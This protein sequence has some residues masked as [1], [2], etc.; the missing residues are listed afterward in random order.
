MTN[1]L[2]ANVFWMFIGNGLYAFMQWIQLSIIAKLCSPI[3][4]GSYTLAL[5]ITAPIFLLLS[6]QL[7]ALIVTDS[8]KE[9]SFSSYFILRTVSLGIS[10]VIVVGYILI[11]Q[12]E[13]KILFLIAGL[14]TI[15][16][17]AEIFNAQQ[18]LM[19]KMHY[20]ARSLILKGLSATI[21]IFIGI[22][23]FNSL[24][25]GLI[26][27]IFSNI[28][29]LYYNDFLNCKKLFEQE[30]MFYFQDLRLKSLLIKSLP[31]GI[32]MCI[33]SL[34]TNISKYITE[35]FLGTEKQG[36]YST[37]AY[38]LV[39]GSF[40]NSAIGQSF[41]P[42]MSR[43]YLENRKKEFK[44]LCIKYLSVNFGVG[45]I[46][47]ILTIFGGYYFLKIMFSEAIASYSDLFSLIMLSGIFLYLASAL[48]YTLTSMRIFKV[49]PV[50]NGIVMIANI[51]GCYFFLNRYGIYGVVYASILAFSIQI[52]LTFYFI[53][54]YYDQSRTRCG[55]VR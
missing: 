39:L 23:F 24:P 7:R 15:E 16:G 31:L 28:L 36:I 43:Y 47:F 34:N 50:I 20:V 45:A 10:I 25:M 12:S 19:E 51:I 30:K 13:F 46:L 40:V 35:Y 8:K 6:L 21:S 55:T 3:I 32:V 17:F 29:V 38:C 26:I 33:I 37:L 54:K 18:Q 5:A 44:N 48:G 42:R 1:S 53:C 49:Q 14:K 2:K 27:A 22:F 52:I 9:W 41:S 11:R 4:L